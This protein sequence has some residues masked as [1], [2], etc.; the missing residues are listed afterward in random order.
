MSHFTRV[1]TKIMELKYLRQALDDLHYD[2]A[3]GALKV[4]G[5]ND[6]DTAVDL[7]VKT[8]GYSIGFCKGPQG[9]QIVADWWGVKGIKKRTFIDAVTRRY[10]YHA[11]LAKLAD[12]GFDLVSEEVQE[13]QQVR[14]VMRRMV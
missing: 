9:Y 13:D 5:F 7:L 11:T 2:Y 8:A 10:A 3:E 1:Q 14:L 4:R 12:Q 6:Q